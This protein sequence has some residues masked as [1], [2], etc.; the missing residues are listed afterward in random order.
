MV[1]LHPPCIVRAAIIIRATAQI[2]NIIKKFLVHYFKGTLPKFGPR[3]QKCLIKNYD[4]DMEKYCEQCL[5]IEFVIE[6]S[7]KVEI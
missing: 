4:S 6:Y 3:L 5:V 1:D 2:V 7:L